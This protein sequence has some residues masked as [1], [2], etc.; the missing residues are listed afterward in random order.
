MSQTVDLSIPSFPTLFDSSMLSTLD[1]CERKFYNEYIQHLSPLAISPDLHAGGAFAEGISVVR[2]CIYVHQMSTDDA[3]AEGTEAM[4]RYWGDFEPPHNH[5]KTC[6]RMI[7]ALHYYFHEAWPVESDHI[8][9]IMLAGDKPAVEFSF[10]IPME[11]RHPETNDPIT[12]GGRFDMLGEYRESLL[13]I[14]DEKTT[15]ALGDYWTQ[16]WDM[17]GQFLG[18]TYAA[19]QHGY[20]ADICIIRGIAILKTKFHH[21]EV[22]VTFPNWMVERWWE[23]ANEKVA[24]AKAKWLS[25]EWTYS[26]G[27]ACSAWGGC[28]YKSL[29]MTDK[30]ELQYGNFQRRMW[31]PLEKDPTWPIG[32]PKS[33]YVGNVND[34]K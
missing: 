20:R 23:Q 17:R 24:R 5:N 22:P 3:L 10:A 13:A 25:G 12:F 1:S 8:H 7:M 31:N 33:E 21:L 34:L 15:K 2:T 26:F 27:D 4:M 14:V 6:E 30:P 32:G 29:C 16:Q 19:G 11:V 18:Y 28:T 9:P